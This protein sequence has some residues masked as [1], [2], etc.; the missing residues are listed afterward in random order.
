MDRLAK[1]GLSS[2]RRLWLEPLMSCIAMERDYVPPMQT[3][4]GDRLG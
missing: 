2:G 3:I 4:T 1:A